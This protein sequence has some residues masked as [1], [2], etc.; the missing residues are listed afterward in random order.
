[1]R[2]ASLCLL[3]AGVAAQASNHTSRVQITPDKANGAVHLRGTFEANAHFG[4][5]DALTVYSEVAV[6]GKWQ[7]IDLCKTTVAQ[8]KSA[9][10]LVVKTW[11]A[12][13]CSHQDE[14][15]AESTYTLT[16][17]SYVVAFHTTGSSKGV[18]KSVFQFG[19][20]SV[21][22]LFSGGVVQMM[23]ADATSVYPSH[24]NVVKAYALGLWDVIGKRGDIAAAILS[25][26]TAGST[27]NSQTLKTILSS[28]SSSSLHFYHTPCTLQV[29]ENEWGQHTSSDPVVC[30]ASTAQYTWSDSFSFTVNNHDFPIWSDADSI[31]P[32]AGSSVSL[33]EMQKD[34]VAFM[35]GIYASPVGNLCTHVNEVAQGETVGQ[36]ATTIATPQRGYSGN[37]NFFDPDNYLSIS[38]MLFSGNPIV[39]A[40]TLKIL[41]RNGDYI[42]AQGQMPHHFQ[43]TTPIY[44]ALSGEVQTGPNIFWILTCIQYAKL[45][46]DLGFIRGYLPVLR[47]SSKFLTNLITHNGVVKGMGTFEALLNAP[48]SLM[49]DVF[50]RNHYTSDSNA[51]LVILYEA[52]AELE[53]DVGS[54]T[55]AAKWTQL[56][57]ETTR[58]VRKMLW[59]TTTNDHYVTQRNPDGTTR[60]FVDYDANLIAVA[61]GI[62]DTTD[63]S[64]A[65]LGRIDSKKHGMC[66]KSHT[67]VSE[68]YY[69]PSDTT[70]GNTGDSA[71]AM[72]RIAWF[73]SLSRRRVANDTTDATQHKALLDHFDNILMDP[74]REGV[75]NTT[76][77]H[78]RYNCDG[79][80]RISRTPYYFEGASVAAML[81][82]HVRYGIQLGLNRHRVAPFGRDAFHYRA[83]SVNV[84]YS[85]DLVSLRLPGTGAKHFTIEGLAPSTQYDVTTEGCPGTDAAEKVTSTSAGVLTFSATVGTAQGPC[86]VSVKKN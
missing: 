49:I 33:A 2:F 26:E 18:S 25:A 79:S 58:S 7:R 68:V 71:C 84:L 3:F 53:G 73:D 56:A 38:A 16:K 67:W 41:K 82:H 24:D 27:N 70:G 59:N 6:N 78:E 80:Q 9:N 19:G 44:E 5:K 60:D 72:G 54:E 51:M 69:G 48:G 13:N 43:G 34:F 20:S 31:L 75:L 66:P 12:L 81:V 4:T 23:N 55:E 36:I 30:A 35:T 42:N 39:Q 61:A 86:T 52:M 15:H 14:S 28:G 17:G 1:M 57:E 65:V 22:S 45:T 85:T 21:Y 74:I 11:S 32:V 47:K 10:L 64:L 83:G 50:I 63:R 40:E 46:Q 62:P 77:I 8:D 37:Y 29:S 76:W